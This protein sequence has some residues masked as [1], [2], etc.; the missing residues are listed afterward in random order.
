MSTCVK[1]DISKV[2]YDA[3][4]CDCL[5]LFTVFPLCWV[6]RI[7]GLVR[8]VIP[9]T[10]EMRYLRGP[11]KYAMYATTMSFSLEAY[12][13]DSWGHVQMEPPECM[14]FPGRCAMSFQRC[15]LARC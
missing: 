4:E 1:E 8:T 9:A 13:H 3:G 12:M 6:H 10:G 2:H 5:F 15:I 7:W 14:A 11:H